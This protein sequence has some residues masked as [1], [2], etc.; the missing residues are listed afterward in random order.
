MP[1]DP[2]VLATAKKVAA[3]LAK[4]LL[5]KALRSEGIV[6]VLAK[7][8]YWKIENEFTKLHVHTLVVRRSQGARLAAL[9]IFRQKNVIKT[10]HDAWTQ[11]DPSVFEDHVRVCAEMAAGAGD[12][13]G[14]DVLNECR[15]FHFVF[16]SL[17]RQSMDPGHQLMMNMLADLAAQLEAF[18]AG[19]PDVGGLPPLPPP[20]RR[21][22]VF[23]Q[24]LQ[25]LRSETYRI[26]IK[27][28]FSESGEGR[29]PAYFP[30][31]DHYTPLKAVSGGP[32][33]EE[34]DEEVREEEMVARLQLRREEE[35]KK[36]ALSEFL[37]RGKHLLII[38]DPGS[39]KTTFVRFVACV[40]AKD[41]LGDTEA[42]R[43]QHL[44]LDAEAEAP[45]PVFL[46]IA[47]LADCLKADAADV[48][49][50]RAWVWLVRALGGQWGNNAAAVLADRLDAGNC[51][52]LLDGLDEVADEMLRTQVYRVVNAAVEHWQ[53]NRFVVTSRPFGYQAVAGARDMESIRISRFGNDEIL[54]FIQRW[55]T[56][57]YPDEDERNRDAYLPQLCS[58]VLN[59]PTIR[60]LARNPVMLTC[61]CVVHWNEKRLPEGK[62]QLL[63][64]VL[65]W[66]VNAREKERRELGFNSFFAE[67]CFRTLAYAMTD[68]PEG[69]QVGVD[70]LWAADQLADPFLAEMGVTAGR[71][72][73]E[74]RRFLETEMM[75]SGVVIKDQTGDLR[76]WHLS[77][78]EHYAGRTLVEL[79][80][81]E[82]WK[83]V[84]DHLYDPQ[85]NEVIDHFTGCLVQVGRRNVDVLLRQI[86]DETPGDVAAA[87]RMVAVA[88]RLLRL[89]QAYKYE[90]PARVGW[91]QVLARVAAMFD[92]DRAKGVPVAD[93]IGAAEVIGWAG[94]SRFKADEP[95][96]LPIP[97]LPGVELGKYPVTVQEYARF[98]ENGGYSEEALWGEWWG[99]KEW[100]LPEDWEEQLE[101]RNRPVTGVS[102]YEATA[103]CRWL[104]AQTGE[105]Y[106][107]A[108]D[109]EWERAATSS[110]GDYPWGKAEPSEE[111]LNFDGN[112]D[113]PTPVGV[114]PAGAASGGHLDMA[115]NVWEWCE[116]LYEKEGSSRVNRGGSWDGSA[117]DCRSASRGDGHPGARAGL[118]GFRLSRSVP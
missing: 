57:I 18:L 89:L 54:E 39:G 113:C 92:A 13:A 36:P 15:A 85:W 97:G 41:G 70:L 110:D 37:D 11:G 31:E 66:L 111:L 91:V 87:A 52:V 1:F 40:L 72:L 74:A 7:V 16:A 14:I 6:G 65:R 33:V 3:V 48:S 50:S 53:G 47:H 32:G 86:I 9:A 84:K 75:N 24:Y 78:Q 117:G 25:S 100:D 67:E 20:A 96:M 22:E 4:P 98:V 101:H 82:W 80:K 118:L 95:A 19:L 35:N 58:A 56:A 21:D 61:L 64:A 109:D 2:V 23:S 103:Y 90:P 94:D 106:R 63:A 46:R 8:G 115:G 68:Q 73:G 77:F 107:L 83:A 44:G 17:T 5:K 108:T 104:A 10:F 99:K 69:K 88:G 76:F 114:Y 29:Q 116:D 49:G 12:M 112:V 55:V 30:I 27:G 71:Q 26:E 62:A 43:T 79:D 105:G 42:G 102:W 45:T 51:F 60:Q 28:I 81:A 59:V 93:R 34:Q 38:G